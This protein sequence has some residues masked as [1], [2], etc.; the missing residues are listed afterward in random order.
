MIV[1]EN[2]SKYYGSTC[3][4]RDLSFKVE[5][6]ECVGFLGLNGAGKSTVLRLLSCLLLPTC[7]RI[8]IRGLD[9]VEH[10]HDIRKFVGYLP[11]LPPLYPEMT[12]RG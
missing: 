9:V 10:A 7:G 2:I 4:V 3:A 12:V 1:V 6:G 5:Q 11:E 8:A